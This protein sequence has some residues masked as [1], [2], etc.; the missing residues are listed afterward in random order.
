[1]DVSIRVCKKC[2]VEKP[3]AA[4]DKHTNGYRYECKECIVIKTTKWN[5]DNLDRRHEIQKKYREAN[6]HVARRGTRKHRYLKTYGITPE[7]FEAK[8]AE[9]NFECGICD[10]KLRLSTGGGGKDV[11]VMDHCHKTGKLRNV[12][13]SP[14]NTSLGGFKDDPVLLQKALEYLERWK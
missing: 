7:E 12:L 9:Q 2:L 8:V 5:Q 3:I 13:C 4:F 14:C 6:P 1:M 10:K 11:A